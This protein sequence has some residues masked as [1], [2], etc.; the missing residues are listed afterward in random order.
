MPS[1]EFITPRDRPSHDRPLLHARAVATGPC[2]PARAEVDV[3][4]A[5][6]ERL[7]A[8]AEAQVHKL[9]EARRQHSEASRLRERD[10]SVRDRRGLAEEKAAA[11]AEYRAAVNRAVNLNSVQEAAATWLNRINLLNHASREADDR[12]DALAQQVND[13]ERTLPGLEMAADAAR[14]ASEAAQEGCLESRR[15]LAECEEAPHRR[16]SP[17]ATHRAASQSGVLSAVVGPPNPT[18]DNVAAPADAA[19][20]AAAARALMRGDRRTMLGLALRLAE[21]TGFEAGRLQLL[22][23]ELREQITSRALEDLAVL[24]PSTHPFWG[25]FPAESAREVAASLASMGFRFD[26]TGGWVDARVPQTRDLAVALSYCGYEPRSLRRPAGQAA[27]DG[28]WEGVVMATEEYL[29]SRA[30]DLELSEIVALLGPASGRLSELWD[31]WGRL[32]PLLVRT[33][34]ET[35]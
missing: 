33:G 11:Q 29:L 26:G 35:A 31:I 21:E 8:E 34:T 6:A 16:G 27:L 19:A 3:R 24:F 2:G 12:A 23:L 15:A 32:R 10:N 25:Q 9:R 5:D 18:A 28:L 14:I 7:L 17:Q 4:C 13:L 20:G 1:P 22:L 30:P